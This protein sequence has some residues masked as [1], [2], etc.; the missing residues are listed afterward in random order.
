MRRIRLSLLVTLMLCL[1]LAPCIVGADTTSGYFD[2]R[3]QDGGAVITRY[4]F[5]PYDYTVYIP[6]TLDGYPVIG[7]ASGAFY[8]N[9]N[10][11][12]VY[13][14]DG[15]QFIEEGAFVNDFSSIS[16]VHLSSKTKM[17]PKAVPQWREIELVI[18]GQV[19]WGGSAA[20]TAV[21]A[22]PTPMPTSTPIPSDFQYTVLAD[23]TSVCITGYS[24]T[25]T[26]V[27]IPAMIGPYQVTEIGG[28]AF[29]QQLD[30][31]RLVIPEGVTRIDTNAFFNCV[32][33]QSII[34]PE[35]VTEIG[36]DAFVN[37]AS[38]ADVT[39]PASLDTPDARQHAGLP[40]KSPDWPY[41]LNEDG[42]TITI[43]AYKGADKAV[44][45]PAAVDGYP[46][47]AIGE[48][49]FKAQAITGVALPEGVTTLGSYAFWGCSDLA[50]VSLPTTLT[51]IST[52]AFYGTL[53]LTAIALPDGLQAIGSGAFQDSGL[54]SVTLP[55]SVT[56]LGE[57]AF[58][59]CAFLAQVELG[60]GIASIDEGTFIGCANLTSLTIPDTVQ[61]I[62]RNAFKDCAALAQVE[63][64]G[65][66]TA[67]DENAFAGCANLTSLTVPDTVRSLGKNAFA[68][69]GF[70]DAADIVLPSAVNTTDARQYAG[71][72][73]ETFELAQIGENEWELV[74][75]NGPDTALVIPESY[76]GKQITRIGEKA[77]WVKSRL[78]SVTLPDTVTTIAPS[79][80]EDCDSLST[81]VMG[82][83]VRSIYYD[84]F[85]GCDNLTSVTFAADGV[86][87][88]LYEDSFADCPNLVAVRLPD[89]MDDDNIVR[90]EAGLPLVPDERL[91][92]DWT[93]IESSAGGAYGTIIVHFYGDGTGAIECQLANGN[94]L[95]INMYTD[96]SD[97]TG[98]IHALIVNASG[99]HDQAFLTN[100]SLFSL[101]RS[102]KMLRGRIEDGVLS[103]RDSNSNSIRCVPSEDVPQLGTLYPASELL[104]GDWQNI[105][106]HEGEPAL[107]ITFEQDGSRAIIMV[108]PGGSVDNFRVATF[109]EQQGVLFFTREATGETTNMTYQLS[110]DGQSLSLTENGYTVNLVRTTFEPSLREQLEALLGTATAE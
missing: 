91:H 106:S 67:I 50:N 102:D 101:S 32:R 68:R 8:T 61:S 98:M 56:R 87:V 99:D 83:N 35:S 65:G 34:I 10:C 19:T 43:T 109:R 51:A 108:V 39:L 26:D 47:T 95:L 82:K 20:V 69:C 12:E 27:T 21:P 85:R 60:S 49:A 3:V 92:G 30:L 73:V 5:E 54:V 71:L 57:S 17:D 7:I 16:T 9:Y 52:Q 59:N 110:P 40:L 58:E 23:G 11:G 79:A 107:N 76:N 72:P 42:I 38:L 33:L 2:Y 29:A 104:F 24:G 46:V 15:V 48:A 88:S 18:D 13:V 55:D 64:G 78:T 97:V 53:S 36:L 66:I 25:A 93:A 74:R 62:G 31:K 103:L 86:S 14:P 28:N 90:A 81:V 63:L 45:V 22:T 6:E 4:S 96:Y 75:Y 44:T 80:F 1:C 70:R 100:L 37:C 105:P 89:G 77:F 41:T 84:A 94:S